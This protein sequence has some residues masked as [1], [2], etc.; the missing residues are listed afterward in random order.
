MVASEW[1]HLI[2]L[3]NKEEETVSNGY[4]HTAA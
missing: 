4:T 1:M 2:Q 3:Y